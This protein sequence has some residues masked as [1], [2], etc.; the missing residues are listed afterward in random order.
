MK[1]TLYFGGKYKIMFHCAYK[2][3]K[4]PF[5]S[6]QH[7]VVDIINVINSSF[8]QVVEQPSYIGNKFLGSNII[9]FP[10]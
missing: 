7:A 5:Q 6:A 2:L 3:N 1:K 8:T 4:T 10:S 9:G